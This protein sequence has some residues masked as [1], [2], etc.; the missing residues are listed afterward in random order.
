MIK[1]VICA[2]LIAA[3]P[4]IVSA[5]VLNER[6]AR[7]ALYNANRVE[8]VMME[9][10]GLNALEFAAMEEASSQM[11]YYAALAYS[12]DD[13]LLS[14]S[15]IAAADHHSVEAAHQAALDACNELR[16]GD[17]ECIVVSHVRPRNW[18]GGR[19]LQLGATA[20]DDFRSNFRGGDAPRVM[21][22]SPLTGKWSIMKG[23]GAEERAL[24]DCNT[25]AAESGATDCIV[26]VSE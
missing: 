17:A 3:T 15:T 22:I 10:T 20:T 4:T 7:R 16:N 5:D 19:A 8:V 21:V 6:E 26:V 24:S 2:A 18:E 14:N 23:E 9:N 25:R 11:L 13:G 12:P 1:Q